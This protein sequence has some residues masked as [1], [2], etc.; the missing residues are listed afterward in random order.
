MENHG[1]DTIDAGVRERYGVDVGDSDDDPAPVFYAVASR[2]GP[3]P[4]EDITN[5]IHDR[6]VKYRNEADPGTY[7]CDYPWDGGCGMRSA[8]TVTRSSP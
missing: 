6:T 1:S 8:G 4:D 5:L 2:P 3:L 7:G